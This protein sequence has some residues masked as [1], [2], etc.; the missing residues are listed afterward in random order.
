MGQSTPSDLAIQVKGNQLSRISN[1]RANLEISRDV[2]V[3]KRKSSTSSKSST[4]AGLP[5]R[6]KMS[7]WGKRGNRMRMSQGEGCRELR[8]ESA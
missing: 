4:Q 5:S 6:E 3:H 1:K 8:V 2:E 7:E